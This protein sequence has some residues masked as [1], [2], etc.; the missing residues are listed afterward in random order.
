MSHWNALISGYAQHGPGE[1]ALSSFDRMQ[2]QGVSPDVITFVC[3]LKECCSIRA[4]EKGKAI[5]VEILKEGL[6]EKHVLVG[7]ALVNMYT[8]C[9]ELAKAQMPLFQDMPNMDMEMK[10]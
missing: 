10:H 4:F 8:K 7:N 3:I 2:R 6:L 5:H 1:K 9:G